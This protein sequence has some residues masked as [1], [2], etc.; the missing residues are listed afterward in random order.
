MYKPIYLGVN[1][2]HVATIRQARGSHYP[3]PVT[4]A[5]IAEQHGADGITVHLREDKRHI[6][7][8]DVQILKQTLQTRL[9]FEMAVCD[10]M[11]NF[12]LKIKPKYCCLVPEKREEL[13]TE[14]GLDVITHFKAIKSACTQLMDNGIEVSLFIDSEENQIIAAKESGATLIELHTG[15]YALASD[16]NEQ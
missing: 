9:N 12:A 10:E 7:P 11:I 8:R 1:V 13:T 5:L 2:D 6:Q 4:A 15:S 16:E 14:G 3:D